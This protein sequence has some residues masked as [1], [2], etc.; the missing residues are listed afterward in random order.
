MHPLLPQND[1]RVARTQEIEKQRQN[2]EWSYYPNLNGTPMIRELPDR[3][4][5]FDK[6]EWVRDTISVILRIFGNQ[7]LEDFLAGSSYSKFVLYGI[8]RGWEII[9]NIK[10]VGDLV[11]RN[12]PQGDRTYQITFNR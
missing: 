2:Y 11:N 7:S 5:P 1:D 4:Q 10:T 9:Q 3:E 6:L 12:V 8:T